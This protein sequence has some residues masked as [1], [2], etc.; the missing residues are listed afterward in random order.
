MSRLPNTALKTFNTWASS[1]RRKRKRVYG[2]ISQWQH[3]RKTEES[4][5]GE[6]SVWLPVWQFSRSPSWMLEESG[7]ESGGSHEY[8]ST[9][10]KVGEQSRSACWFWIKHPAAAIHNVIMINITAARKP[11]RS[12]TTRVVT[13]NSVV[14]PF[15]R[16]SLVTPF[17]SQNQC[18]PAVFT[19]ATYVSM[20]P[21]SLMSHWCSD[22]KKTGIKTETQ[23]FSC[24]TIKASG[25]SKCVVPPCH[26][27]CGHEGRS[28]STPLS[29]LSMN[30]RFD[31]ITS[32][33]IMVHHLGSDTC[34][35]LVV[36]CELRPWSW[37]LMIR[38]NL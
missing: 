16:R 33:P 2:L 15:T 20:A 7:S 36:F 22:T 37:W 8:Y 29:S 18:S 14:T 4:E 30:V 24:F 11:A 9:L 26:G 12:R 3:W 21:V 23:Y 31:L 19:R 28:S 5:F 32:V 13:V 10:V 25:R 38:H 35:L 6:A 27:N 34:E 1:R 17:W